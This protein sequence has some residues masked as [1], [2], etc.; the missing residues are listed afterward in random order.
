MAQMPELI[1]DIQARLLEEDDPL[2]Y[3]GSRIEPSVTGKVAVGAKIPVLFRLYNLPPLPEPSS[4]SGNMLNMLATAKLVGADGNVHV[5]EPIPLDTAL[6]PDGK[7][8]ASVGLSLSFPGA[9]AGKYRLVVEVSQPDAS[10]GAGNP[11]RLE[12]DLELVK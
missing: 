9:E 1:R 8:E 3:A 5:S 4:A 12:T 6:S 7:T 10:D 2:I 11:V